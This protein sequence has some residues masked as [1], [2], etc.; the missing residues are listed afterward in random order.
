MTSE[1]QHGL[2]LFV[3]FTLNSVLEYKSGSQLTWIRASQE[4]ASLTN[5]ERGVV[6]KPFWQRP[7][8]K[9]KKKKRKPK[10]APQG[11]ALQT[12]PKSKP[13]PW[14]PPHPVIPS[15]PSIEGK[16]LA[17]PSVTYQV[18]AVQEVKEDTPSPSSPKSKVIHH[19][20]EHIRKEFMKTFQSLTNRWRS[21]DISV[22]YTHLTLPTK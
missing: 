8:K 7:P 14:V 13:T 2:G 11:K 3:A 10:A 4:F 16:F 22:S 1:S 18:P 21:W 17:K 19:R 12:I 5:A 15:S 20:N 9:S 6:M